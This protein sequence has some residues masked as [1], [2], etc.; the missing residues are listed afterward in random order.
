MEGPL[1]SSELKVKYFPYSNKN[2]C[3]KFFYN[4]PSAQDPL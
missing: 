3:A 4:P 1:T 2:E